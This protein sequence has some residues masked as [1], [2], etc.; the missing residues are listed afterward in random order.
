[1]A[2]ALGDAAG[3]AAA[4][5]ATVYL[6]RTLGPDRYGL[7]ALAAAITLYP[8]GLADLGIAA[9]GSRDV[10]R[11]PVA[12]RRWAAVLLTGRFAI[13][14]AAAAAMAGLAHLLLGPPGSTVFAGYALTLLAVGLNGTWV[15]VGLEDARPA[16]VARVAGAL[17]VLAATFALVRGADDVARAPLAVLAGELCTVGAVLLALRRRGFRVAPRFDPAFALPVFRRALPMLGHTLLGLCIF[18]ADLVLVRVFR[19]R[20]AVGNYAAAYA[21]VTLLVNGTV[22]YGQ[23]LVAALTRLRA[24]GQDGALLATA[25]ARTFAVALPAALG[26]AVLAPRIIVTFFAAGYG[27]APPALALLLATVPLA[28]LRSTATAALVAGGGGRA[29]FRITAA[30]AATA[31]LLDLV[32]IPALGIL[33]AALASV[34]TEAVHTAWA[35]RGARQLGFPGVALRR[36]AVPTAAA[37]V[38]TGALLPVAG[39]PLWLSVALG[40]LVYGGGLAAVGALRLDA[41]GLPT[42]RV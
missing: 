33:G 42:L 3:R 14:C 8:A 20:P 16:G 2:L 23:S 1:M 21:L 27:D 15:L 32:L 18:N 17:V 28:A 9:I 22:I 25:Y 38:M 10:A 4:F 30:A 24:T 6:A 5:V 39:G 34:A 26:G 36:L 40:A 11:D 19:D 35:L 31:V 41:R 29:L 37:A 7:V 13:A 12:A